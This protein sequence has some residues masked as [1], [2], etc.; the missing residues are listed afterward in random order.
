MEIRSD[1][2]YII[3]IDNQFKAITGSDIILSMDMEEEEIV[4]MYDKN[5]KVDDIKNAFSVAGE[6]KDQK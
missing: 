5:S 3:K 2:I 4:V 1:L 6:I